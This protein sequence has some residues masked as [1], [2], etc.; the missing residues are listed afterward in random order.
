MIDRDGQA[1]Q[2]QGEAVELD[3]RLAPDGATKST[4]ASG[5]IAM[6]WNQQRRQ[7]T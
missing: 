7:G 4:I 6:R 5:Y 3:H 1:D 2:S